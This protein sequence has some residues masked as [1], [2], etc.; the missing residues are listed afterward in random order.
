MMAHLQV[1]MDFHSST[2]SNILENYININCINVQVQC[3]I[4]V[5]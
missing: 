5:S 1:F 4:H 2:V 3:N